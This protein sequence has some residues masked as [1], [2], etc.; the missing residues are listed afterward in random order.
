[1]HSASDCSGEATAVVTCGHAPR[2]LGR[3]KL[4]VDNHC[5]GIDAQHI[6]HHLRAHGHVT[7]ARW[8]RCDRHI[9]ATLQIDCNGCAGNRPVL[10]PCLGTLLGREHRADV[11]HVRDRRFDNRG[12]TNAVEFASG[13]RGITA[14]PKFLNRRLG[15]HHVGEPKIISRIENGSGGSLIGELVRLNIIAPTQFDGID[16]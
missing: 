10:W 12:N 8:R 15:H 4:D 14:G 7:L 11:A 5:L 6:G 13:A 9:D 16:R 2:V 3:I 1:M